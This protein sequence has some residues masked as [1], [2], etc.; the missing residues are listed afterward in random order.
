MNLWN[1]ICVFLFASLFMFIVGVSKLLFQFCSYKPQI[2]CESYSVPQS[3][4]RRYS[5][6]VMTKYQISQ[7]RQFS[8]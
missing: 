5:D 8:K 4:S 1:I 2:S 3:V 7:A 6:F